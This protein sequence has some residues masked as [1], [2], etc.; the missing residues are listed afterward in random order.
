M[1]AVTVTARLAGLDDVPSLVWLYRG[2]EEEMTALHPM[3]PMADGLAEPIE[4]SFESLLEDPES[5]V[6]IRGVG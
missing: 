1:G 5:L 6:V 2:L 3:W 4:G